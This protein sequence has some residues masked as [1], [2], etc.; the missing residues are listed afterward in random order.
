MVRKIKLNLS[1]VLLSVPITT[2][3]LENKSLKGDKA[4]IDK[5][6]FIHDY[7]ANSG[8]GII[9]KTAGF[10]IT[11]GRLRDSLTLQRMN[12]KMLD[13]KYDTAIN[14]M[15][16]YNGQRINYGEYGIY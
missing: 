3:Y 6:Q 8:T 13:I 2:N 1:T 14:I 5:K 9:V 12:R 4:G 7:K 15:Q 10:A 16:D 11:N